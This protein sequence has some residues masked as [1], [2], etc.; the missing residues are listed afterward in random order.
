MRAMPAKSAALATG[1][2]GLPAPPINATA[3]IT[4]TR[5]KPNA[6]GLSAPPVDQY[7]APAKPAAAAPVANRKR[8][9]VQ[10]SAAVPAA[11]QTIAESALP[12]GCDGPR[13]R[14][15]ASIKSGA[16]SEN[17]SVTIEYDV[18]AKRRTTRSRT[19]PR[20]R[21][22]NALAMAQSQMEAPTRGASDDATNA[23]HAM[24]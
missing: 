10:A 1:A 12:A 14:C 20:S 17:E 18:G 23:P 7:S 21:P 4:P 3:T 9:P 6:F 2:S 24:N 16:A 13:V 15:G 8:S 19:A 11:R 5:S 22:V